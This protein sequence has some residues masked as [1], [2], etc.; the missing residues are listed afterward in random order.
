VT[1]WRDVSR[2][3]AI[4]GDLN[5]GMSAI[6]QDGRPFARQREINPGQLREW[7]EQNIGITPFAAMGSNLDPEEPRWMSYLTATVHRDDGLMQQHSL[8]PTWVETMFL[9]ASRKLT[10][11]YP[12]YRRQNP[13]KTG[14]HLLVNGLAGG[15]LWNILKMLGRAGRADS[16]LAAKRLLFQWPATID[17]SGRVIHC[18]C[19]PDAVLK[20]GHLVPLCISDLVV[21]ENGNP[22]KTRLIPMNH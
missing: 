11:R 21:G 14:L 16:R 19:C 12:F 5:G 13:W 8:R 1:W 7:M 2:M 6:R 18:A 15:G 17:E 3:P 20:D 4:T 9:A 10:G 22:D